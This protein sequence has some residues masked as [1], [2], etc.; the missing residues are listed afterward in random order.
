MKVNAPIQWIGTT[1]NLVLT[2]FNQVQYECEGFLDKN[3]DT[4]FEELINILK[5]SQVDHFL[6][7]FHLILLQRRD[8]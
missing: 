7:T 2:V 6:F 1:C 4:V 3:R 5:A 8:H